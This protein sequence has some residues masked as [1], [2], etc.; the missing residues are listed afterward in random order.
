MRRLVN[1]QTLK[2]N[3]NPLGHNQLRQ[4][5]A[6]VAL[7]TL[8]MANTQRS[9]SNMPSSLDS[10]TNLQDVD[11]SQNSLPRV[12]DALYTLPNLKRL[13][14]SE[15][16][17]IDISPDIGDLWKNLVTLNLSRNKLK[18]LPATLC[19]L[20]KLRRLY[21]NDN[22]LDFDG[23]PS[24]IGKL[25]SLEVF[26]A[27]NNNLE[28]I[29]E[30]VVRCGRL[31]KL[32]LSN[33]RL[34][35]L[36]E[37]I[38]LL[39]DLEVLD[40][41]G[42]PD[43]IMPPKPEELIM[44]SGSEYYNIDFSLSTQLRLAGATTNNP[45]AAPA[46]SKDPIARKQ[47]L[48]RKKE[49]EVDSDQ[50]KVLKGMSDLAK[51]KKDFAQDDKNVSLKPKRWDEAL[52]KPPL[53]YSDFFD[54]EV[55]Q[56]PG[57]TCWEIENFLP[58]QVDEALIGKFYEGD[59][60]IILKTSLDENQS[61]DW[62]IFYWIGSHATLDKKACSAIH[63]VNLR[64]FLGAQCRTIREEQGD[65]SD[66]FLDLF[67]ADIVYIEGGRTASGFYTIEEVEYIPRLYRLE[68]NNRVLHIESFPVEYECLDPRYVFL[69][70]VGKK[71][72]IW[73]GKRSKNTVQSKARLLAEKMNKNERKNLS[74][75]VTFT[76]GQEAPEF[77]KLAG[78]EDPS[79]PIPPP[80]ENSEDTFVNVFPTLYQVGLGMGYLE[81]PQVEI[82]QKRLE[83]KLLE[84]K[85]VYILDCSTDVFVWLGQKSTRLV[86][87]A[88]L[89]LSQE[90]CAMIKRP[91]H[92]IVSRVLEGNG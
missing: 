86:R 21:I 84:T 30:G 46:H 60:Y 65:E 40:L 19:K 7:Q 8:H 81:L 77:L 70:D 64:N 69:L 22:Q 78:I 14:L 89:K 58:N 82:K 76:Q 33:N 79:L 15:N 23:I 31:K 83:K 12:P 85:N 62:Q 45:V 56:V 16:C 9:L 1:L 36:P 74:E 63:A 39:T 66:E 72:Y 25:Y 54:E 4:L 68:T 11:L 90:L 48:R 91:K 26:M 57:L 92:A 28:M 75:I 27:S 32:V 55:G 47:R 10:L 67:G 61:L 37:A 52:E 5:P 38:H 35:T 80:T 3:N 6:L 59:C 18:A 50:A 17:I 87:A 34:I 41:H 13:N 29:P 53:D 88:A 49:D 51:D 71:I 42:N 24:G 44:G 43:L 73:Y 20:S 2:L